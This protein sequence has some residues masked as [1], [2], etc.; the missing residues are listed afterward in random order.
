M[1]KS[2]LFQAIYVFC[3]SIAE[4]FTIILVLI[5]P[6]LFSY[7]VSKKAG[8]ISMTVEEINVYDIW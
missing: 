6:W 4:Y 2:I 8:Q 1:S 3:E 7:N 5:S